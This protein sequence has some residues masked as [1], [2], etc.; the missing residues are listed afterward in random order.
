MHF[1]EMKPQV[2]AHIETTADDSALQFWGIAS[3][4]SGNVQNRR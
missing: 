1:D 4:D 2:S 3:R